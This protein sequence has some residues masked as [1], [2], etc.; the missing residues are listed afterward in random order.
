MT[1]KLLSEV[2]RKMNEV[3]EG[4]AKFIYYTN[5]SNSWRVTRPP[6]TGMYTIEEARY[7][8]T[9][10]LCQLVDWCEAWLKGAEEIIAIFGKEKL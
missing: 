3:C 10:T 8:P 2:V 7:S 5:G 1:D 6:L 9:L 4:R